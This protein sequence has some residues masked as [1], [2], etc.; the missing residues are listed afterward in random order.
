MHLP[1]TFHECFHSITDARR[2]DG[3][4]DNRGYIGATPS[5]RR[6]S[7]ASHHSLLWNIPST[8]LRLLQPNVVNDHSREAHIRV[9]NS[10]CVL[11]CQERGAGVKN[12]SK[13]VDPSP[14]LAN[15]LVLWKAFP[16]R[17]EYKLLVRLVCLCHA[18]VRL[19]S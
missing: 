3:S 14:H 16:D 19:G 7:F 13:L 15:E 4:E 1:G 18:G 5:S 2:G 8:I 10:T 6:G 11:F 17:V 9:S 12:Y